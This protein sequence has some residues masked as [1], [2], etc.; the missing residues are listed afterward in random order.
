M[1]ILRFGRAD[2]GALMLIQRPVVI[3]WCIGS[4]VTSLAVAQSDSFGSAASSANRKAALEEFLKDAQTYEMTL[5]AAKPIV[6][7]LSPQPVFNWDGS[8]FVWLHEGR[9][10]VIGSFWTNLEPRTGRVRHPHAL[11]SLSEHPIEARFG[12]TIVWSPRQPG[13]KFRPIPAAE[14]PSDKSWRRLVQM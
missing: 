1:L 14:A 9:P 11:H 5:E 8:T 6:L 4:L 10:E 13:L 2:K 7:K 3:C 12:S